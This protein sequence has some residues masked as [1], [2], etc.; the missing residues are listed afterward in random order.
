MYPWQLCARFAWTYFTAPL[1]QNGQILGTLIVCVDRHSGWIVAIPERKVGLTGAKVA[2]AMVKN[3][4]RPFGAPSVIISDQG[5]QF[6]GSWWQTMCG[7]LGIRCAYSQAYLYR[8]NGK[9]ERAAQQI[10]ERLRQKKL[11]HGLTWVEV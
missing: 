6:V 7:A 1:E 9:A 3:Q 4:W 10:F 2:L 11:D 5:S 8:A